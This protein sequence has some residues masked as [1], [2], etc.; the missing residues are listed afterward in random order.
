MASQGWWQ[1]REGASRETWLVEDGGKW[2]VASGGCFL[3]CRL[4]D[5]NL[6]VGD[7]SLKNGRC[8]L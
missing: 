3:G 7:G 4:D 5:S 6:L 2:Q 1:V 8:N